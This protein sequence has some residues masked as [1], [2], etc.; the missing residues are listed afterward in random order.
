MRSSGF[1]FL[2]AALPFAPAY[3]ADA[4]PASG[5][6]KLAAYEVCRPLAVIDMGAAGTEA[7]TECSGVVRNLDPQKQPDN[8]AIHCLETTG[9]RPERYS[10]VGTCV[11]TDGAGDKLF[12]SYNGQ[13]NG[14]FKWIGGTG[15]YKDVEGSGSL[16]VVAAPHDAPGQFAYTL[17]LEANWTAKAK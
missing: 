4:P 11:L 5:S 1:V 2:L 6:A 10:Y 7:A 9:A 15:A 14:E 8:L 3:A 12:M 17:N 13:K 16:S